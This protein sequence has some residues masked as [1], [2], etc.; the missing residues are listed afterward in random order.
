MSQTPERAWLTIVGIGE[1]GL[2]GLS[3]ASREAL[4]QAELVT[5]PARHLALVPDLR[6]ERLTWPVPFTDGIAPLLAQRG[7]RVVLLA[8]GDPFWFGAGSVIA[9][10]LEPWEWTACPAPSTFGL[11]A[12]RLGWPIEDTLCLGLHAAPLARLRPHL[13][14]GRRALVLVRD[15]KA[16]GELCRYL[17]E[18]GFGASAVT[19]LEALG[20]PRERVREATAATLAFDD[21]VHP[22]AL[23]IVFA[24]DGVVLPAAAG[25]PDD[26]F[27]HDGQITKRP[28]RALT[29]SAL[30]PR[31]GE[32]LWDIGTG[33]GSIA[34]E[35][36]LAHPTT[37]AIGFEANA[38][39]AARARANAAALG[40]DR[41][42]VIE[43]MAPAVLA[44]QPSPQ[45]VFIG[46]GLSAELLQALA[47]RLAPGTRLVANAVTLESETLLA[48]WHA[49]RGG[50]LLRIDLAQAA[51]LGSR[52]GW[53]ASYP[54]VQWS[55]TL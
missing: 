27:E 43:G 38:E 4:A 3:D 33:S 42:R 11:A 15:G 19:V 37:Q 18:R 20:G 5:G 9:R 39:R 26:W 8:S 22:V 21:I 50:S 23:G 10:E 55:V 40:V 44:D 48:Q 51:P 30:A 2:S 53:Q 24:G 28:V 17:D 32:T 54:I 6:C 14:P 49:E 29:L 31:P 35:W 12:S 13:A 41:L 36:L 45:A 7:R 52:R 46:G 25:R 34:I 1:D 16:V 47:D